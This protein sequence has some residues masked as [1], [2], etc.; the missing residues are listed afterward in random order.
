MGVFPYTPFK[1]TNLF[2]TIVTEGGRH[3][4]S[5]INLGL[6]KDLG[7]RVKKQTGEDKFLAFFIQCG[8]PKRV[9]CIYSLFVS[10]FS[11]NEPL[12]YCTFICV[13][14]LVIIMIIISK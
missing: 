8:H 9:Q 3:V 4:I 6:I 2:L 7:Y 11:Y 5:I 1:W 12:F 14:T 10:S 13:V